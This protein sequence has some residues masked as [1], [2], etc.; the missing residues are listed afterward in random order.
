MLSEAWGPVGSGTSPSH[1]ARPVGCKV[2]TDI[3][4]NNRLFLQSSE[5]EVSKGPAPQEL[6]GSQWDWEQSRPQ[7]GRPEEAAARDT[8]QLAQDGGGWG[9]GGLE[10][11]PRCGDQVA[12]E[13]EKEGIQGP[14][15]PETEVR[16]GVFCSEHCTPP[17][18]PGEQRPRPG[19]DSKGLYF[20]H[21]EGRWAHS[22]SPRS[23]GSR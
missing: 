20:W 11:T 8:P 22:P 12:M 4:Y 6:S 5:P 3:F 13:R 2:P 17:P 1:Q 7:A 23:Q 9:E 19:Q 15:V 18:A 14:G 16:G 10:G 21:E